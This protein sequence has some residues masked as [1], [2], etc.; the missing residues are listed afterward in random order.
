VVFLPGVGPVFFRQVAEPE[1]GDGIE[2]AQ[3][4]EGFLDLPLPHGSPVLERQID[5]D[6]ESSSHSFVYLTDGFFN[7]NPTVTV[8]VKDLAH[9]LGCLAV[10]LRADLKPIQK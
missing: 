3:V 1:D 6:G 8:A 10:N 2:L 9:R 5:F 4:P 7:D